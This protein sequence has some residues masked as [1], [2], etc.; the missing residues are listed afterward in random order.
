MVLHFLEFLITLNLNIQN[1]FKEMDLLQICLHEHII[2]IKIDA[3]LSE[4]FKDENSSV[5][6]SGMA[7]ADL[8]NNANHGLKIPFF[9]FYFIVK[10]L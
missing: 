5:L 6:F 7:D 2:I 3:A 8:I 4:E 9:Y 1:I 10:N